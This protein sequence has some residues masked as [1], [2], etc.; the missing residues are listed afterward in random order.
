MIKTSYRRT[1]EYFALNEDRYQQMKKN[2]LLQKSLGKRTVYVD[3]TIFTSRISAKVAWSNKN[4]NISVP[5]TQPQEKR[6]NLVA[7]I[8]YEHG[9]EGW[10]LF[11]TH[12]VDDKVYMH[13]VVFSTKPS[14]I[15]S[16]NYLNLDSMNSL[17]LFYGISLL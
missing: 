17:R 11:N 6:I 5:K 2:L 13:R 12:A 8:S 1:A 3:E 15:F 16:Q 10:H 9:L 7:G 4:R 14:F